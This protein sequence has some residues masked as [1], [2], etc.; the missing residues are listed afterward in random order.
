M[1]LESLAAITAS[2]GDQ[3]CPVILKIPGFAAM[4]KN[5]ENGSVIPFTHKKGNRP[6]LNINTQ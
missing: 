4:K 5:R 3:V 6:I 1:Q 2:S